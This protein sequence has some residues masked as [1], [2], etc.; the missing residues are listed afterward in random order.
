[1]WRQVPSARS[2]KRAGSRT[3]GV[4]T[5]GST[6][7]YW[8]PREG[9]GDLVWENEVWVAPAKGGAGR[10]LTRALDRN[11]FGAQWMPDGKSLL[12]AGNDRTVSVRGFSRSTDRRAVSTW[13][14]S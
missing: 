1:M 2:P 9:R 5:D 11:L 13:A 12:I 10:S 8:Y 4:L 7:A 14:T 6:I 3:T